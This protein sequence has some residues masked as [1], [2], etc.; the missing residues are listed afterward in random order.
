MPPAIGRG[1]RQATVDY[2]IPGRDRH[3]AWG[4]ASEI[5]LPVAELDLRQIFSR[6]V[7][8]LDLFDIPSVAEPFAA[9]LTAIVA[10]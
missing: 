10:P 6:R 3:E 5:L 4:D 2:P 8:E 1:C 7:Q 9:R